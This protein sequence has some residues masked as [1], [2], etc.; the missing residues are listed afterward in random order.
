M[1]R[2][3]FIQLSTAGSLLAGTLPTSAQDPD[4]EPSLA[5]GHP[6]TMAP[7]IDGM[8]IVWRINGLAKGYVEFGL[9]K[10]LGQIARNDGWGLIPAG[11][12]LIKVRLNQLQPGTTYHYRTVTESFDTKTP[13]TERGEL[14]TF[15]TLSATAEHT[16]FSVWNDT[17]KHNDTIAKLAALTPPSDFLIWNGDI[18]ND[19]NKDGELA[20]SILTPGA[21]VDFTAQSPLL[22]LRGNH[23]LRGTLAY[24]FEETVATPDGKPWCAFRS[25][26]VAVICMDTGEDKPDDHPYLFG[27]AAC[28]PMRREQAAW[29]EQVI[30]R[31]EIKSAPYRLMFCHIPL[32]WTH[33]DAKTSY[34][35]FSK[36]SRNLWHHSL[37]KWGAQLVISG[38]THRDAYLEANKDFPYAQLVGGG[39][40]MPQARLIT[41]SADPKGLTITMTN[42]DS[43]QTRNLSF[44]PLS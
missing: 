10:N 1:E 13:G 25:G 22:A 36:R 38:H 12:E 6:V 17:H 32:R 27:R 11:T 15:R 2:R 3:Q 16:T 21:G 41:G 28:E 24:Q 35:H 44:K 20:E 37:V 7:R 4:P 19:W 23:D 33:E 39:P 14:R 42:M 34:D 26:P 40:K 31:P 30:E 43:Q 8:D 18:S 9:D 5:H 29:L